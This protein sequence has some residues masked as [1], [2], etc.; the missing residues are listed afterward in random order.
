MDILITGKKQKY[1]RSGI[2]KMM[3][4]N[5]SSLPFSYSLSHSISHCILCCFGLNSFG[6]ISR[7]S[8]R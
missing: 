2:R 5:L 6:G 8:I 7:L 4:T 1:E 3:L